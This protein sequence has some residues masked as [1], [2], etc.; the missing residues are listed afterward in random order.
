[1][2]SYMMEV[3]KKVNGKYQ[4]VGK[5]EVYY[6]T[7]ADFGLN[8]ESKDGEDGFPVYTDS[9]MQ[10]LADAAIAA[11][12][13]IVRNRLVSGTVELKEGLTIPSSL[14]ELMEGGSGNKGE[15]LAIAREFLADFKAW[16][17]STGKPQV[18]QKSI[19]DVLRV[20]ESIVAQPQAKK[21][22]LRDT[23]LAGFV[24]SLDEEKVERY[25]K[26]IALIAEYCS[27]EAIDW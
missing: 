15:G 1:M 27:S 19:Y 4:P 24:D 8:V 2:K 11:T 20:P 25:D 3:N 5:V 18:V 21:D 22:A 17:A 26:R 14:D 6:P 16:L 12:K 13:A 10:W 23:Y 9:K 7:L